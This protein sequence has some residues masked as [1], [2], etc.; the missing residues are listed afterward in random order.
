MASS[1]V[2]VGPSSFWNVPELVTMTLN[3]VD[4][5]T[6]AV[7]A[8]LNRLLSEHSLDLLYRENPDFLKVVQ[9]LCPMKLML[10]GKTMGFSETL[11]P[12][13]WDRF[14]RYRS[15]IRSLRVEIHPLTLSRESI[16]NL[17]ATCPVGEPIFPSLTVFQWEQI[18]SAVSQLVISLFHEKLQHVTL[19]PISSEKCANDMLEHLTRRAPYLQS[20]RYWNGTQG[21]P[22]PQ[23][24]ES[25]RLTCKALKSL[26][27]VE[28]S[29]DLVTPEL[30][31]ELSTHEPL[32]RLWTTLY[33]PKAPPRPLMEVINGPLNPTFPSLLEVSVDCAILLA[34]PGY[35]LGGPQLMALHIDI[36]LMDN[37][38]SLTVLIPTSCKNLKHLSMFSIVD[39]ARTPFSWGMIKPLLG[40][41]T[42]ETFVIDGPIPPLLSN[43]D[44]E[45]LAD[46]LPAL[47]HLEIC[48]RA[49]GQP[50]KPCPTLACLTSI[51]RSCRNLISVGVYVDASSSPP[52]S[53]S[54]RP[55][56][57]FPTTF[58]TMHVLCSKITAPSSVAD[59]LASIFPP[60]TTLS[61]SRYSPHLRS[62]ARTMDILFPHVDSDVGLEIHSIKYRKLW[63]E[64]S[65]LLDALKHTRE[66]LASRQA[67]VEVLKKR[68]AS[69][70]H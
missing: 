17:L 62:V 53:P 15:R 24:K 40:L 18:D 58:Q 12:S 14:Q 45:R 4:K 11:K 6:L 64:T 42:L 47:R 50:R 31:Q 28:L 51:A 5:R 61:F 37:V 30:L 36:L 26:Q 3:Y 65:E 68:L 48:P 27:S 67:E 38:K 59:F 35:Y 69:L 1:S 9:I 13:H 2:L 63:K 52:P 39:S 25:F 43:L 23:T 7:C 60:H 33:G 70:I 29:G 10:G 21:A 55:E 19:L 16:I 54:P 57:T 49:T 46:S 32:T 44:I 22:T 34:Y 66:A 41:K 20:L 8:R 56:H